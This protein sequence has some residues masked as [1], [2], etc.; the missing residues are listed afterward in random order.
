M[1]KHR[2]QSEDKGR[3]EHDLCLNSEEIF[4]PVKV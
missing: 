2:A 3:V 1:R 4:S